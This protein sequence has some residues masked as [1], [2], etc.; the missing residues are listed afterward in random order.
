MEPH[1]GKC[2]QYSSADVGHSNDGQA[3]TCD[4]VVW[5]SLS[6]TLC[7]NMYLARGVQGKSLQNCPIGSNG[8]SNLL[9]EK[10]T[11]RCTNWRR[12]PHVKN[13]NQ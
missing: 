8:Y 11:T 3:R 2:L 5:H 4:L 1:Y 13:E 7:E 9:V 6:L 10:K 12:I